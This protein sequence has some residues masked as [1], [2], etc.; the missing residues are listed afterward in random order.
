MSGFSGDHDEYE[1]HEFGEI[2]LLNMIQ[3]AK[4]EKLQSN[5]SPGALA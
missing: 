4:N 5:H 3:A 2:V 1:Q